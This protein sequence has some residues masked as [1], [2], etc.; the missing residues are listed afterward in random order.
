MFL[1]TDIVD[2]VFHRHFNDSRERKSLRNE[3]NVTPK[4]WKKGCVYPGL[5]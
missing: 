3:K 5:A 1:F 2:D 4:L